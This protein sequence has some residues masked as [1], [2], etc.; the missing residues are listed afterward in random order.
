MY[1][2]VDSTAYSE[3]MDFDR[4]LGSES[5]MGWLERLQVRDMVMTKHVIVEQTMDLVVVGP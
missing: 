1:I 3:L 4:R 2:T 5:V